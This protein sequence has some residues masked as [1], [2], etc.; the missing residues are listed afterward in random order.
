M[1]D[2]LK[3]CANCDEEIEEG[4]GREPTPGQWLCQECHAEFYCDDE[5]VEY[6]R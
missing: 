2:K 6:D 5:G 3:I 4:Y 1:S